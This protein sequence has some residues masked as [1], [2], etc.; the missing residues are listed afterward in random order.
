[1]TRRLAQNLLLF[2]VVSLVCLF[3]LELVVRHQMP[4]FH[5]AAQIG[6][7]A[8]TNGLVLGPANKSIRQATPK[9][10]YD[11][12][13]RVNRSGFRER[14]GVDTAADRDWFVLGDSNSMGWGIDEDKRYSNALGHK[15]ASQV[16]RPQVFNIALPENIIGINACFV[17]RRTAARMSAASWLV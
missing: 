7:V 16:S 15:L 4:F 5:P 9:G 10:D 3:V 13:I 11:L 17:M 8:T 6:F 12:T 2:A 1:L 14:K